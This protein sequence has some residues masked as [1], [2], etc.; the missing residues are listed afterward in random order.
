[1]TPAR[2]VLLA[3]QYMRQFGLVGWRFDFNENKRRLGVC[4]QRKKRIELSLEYI[5]N[6]TDA[7][8]IDTIK[9]EIAHAL[10]GPGH[11]HGPVWKAKAVELGCTPA[12]CS[13]VAQMPQGRF[14][15][16]CPN[17]GKIHHRYRCPEVLTGWYC[18]ACGP[19]VGLLTWSYKKKE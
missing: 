16:T 15:A 7:E 18:K 3:H 17:C 5:A 2:A 13:S 11:G 9:H 19:K 1:M 10:V 6:N 14:Q 12:A 4:R 8:V